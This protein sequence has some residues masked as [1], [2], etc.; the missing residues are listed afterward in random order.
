MKSSHP[1]PL[2]QSMQTGADSSS[3]PNSLARWSIKAFNPL[4]CLALFYVRRDAAHICQSFRNTTR[5]AAGLS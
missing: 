2:L 4:S 3:R 1:S 5:M